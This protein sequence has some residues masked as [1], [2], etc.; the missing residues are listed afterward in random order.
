MNTRLS[1]TR[2][3][4]NFFLSKGCKDKEKLVDLIHIPIGCSPDKYLGLPL[5]QNYLK[6]KD[7]IALIDKFRNNIEGKG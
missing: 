6:A 3:R 4:V 7:C 1:I 5:S 2:G